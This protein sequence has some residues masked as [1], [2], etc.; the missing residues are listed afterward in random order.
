MML[1]SVDYNVDIALHDND[2]EVIY[3]PSGWGI[4]YMV[5]TFDLAGEYVAVNV[6]DSFHGLLAE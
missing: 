5:A 2:H 4:P 6:S 3:R 1:F